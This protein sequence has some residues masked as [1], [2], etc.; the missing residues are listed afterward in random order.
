MADGEEVDRCAKIITDTQSFHKL[1]DTQVVA[2]A[3]LQ[4]AEEIN[5]LSRTVYD[6]RQ[7]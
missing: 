1:T 3:I 4:L 7:D 5:N 2:V 6:T